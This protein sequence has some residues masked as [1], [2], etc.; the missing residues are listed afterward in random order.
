MCAVDETIENGVSECGVPDDGVP[1]VEGELAGDE[2]C[3]P[4]IPI[5]KDFQHITPL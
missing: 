1:V 5:F 2:R 3:A 4:S